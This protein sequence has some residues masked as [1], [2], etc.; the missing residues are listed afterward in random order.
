MRWS[1]I[2]KFL[3]DFLKIA[4]VLF[5]QIYFCSEIVFSQSIGRTNTECF[6][7]AP[8]YGSNLHPGGGKKVSSA[9]IFCLL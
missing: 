3:F 5:I 4:L 6:T 9:A 8:L 7:N 1:T 2:S